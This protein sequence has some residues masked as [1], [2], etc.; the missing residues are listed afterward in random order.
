MSV[1][2]AEILRGLLS[3]AFLCPFSVSGKQIN[4]TIQLILEEQ[5][6][7]IKD[8]GFSYDLMPEN[9]SGTPARITAVHKGRFGI[10]SDFGEGYAQLKSKE[11]YYDGEVFPTAGD[12][13]L[14]D[15]VEDGDSRITATLKRKSYFSRRDPDKGRG[16]QAVAANFDYVFIMQ[17]LNEDFNPKR[18]ERYLTAAGQ[19]GAEPVIILTKADLTEDYLPYILEVSRVAEGIPVHIV[20]AKTGFGLQ[21]LSGYLEK[22]RTLVFMGSSGVGKSSLVN[23]LAGKEIM[24]VNGIR[25]D[26][27]KG[28]HTTTHRELIMLESGVM[29]IDT[30]GMRELGMWDVTEGLGEAFADVEK[31]TG[32]C[33]FRDCKHEGEPGCA[34][35]EAIEKGELDPVRFES[36]KKI[37]AEAKYSGDKTDF[38]RRKQQWGKNIRKYEKNKKKE[39]W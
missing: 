30:P 8:Y 39:V 38:L 19:S 22:G 25:E 13:V 6:L 31:Y 5:K 27:S 26:D 2:A 14:I 7:N 12:F 18:L 3:A 20:S 4:Y 36:Y 11:Y 21:E 10:V 28:R 24:D 1:S 37:K 29:I 34:V 33:K 35:R 16:E 23:T 17:S 15:Y 32:K 9:A